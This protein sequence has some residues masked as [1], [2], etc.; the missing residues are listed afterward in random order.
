MWAAL[1]VTLKQ[2]HLQPATSAAGLMQTA[3]PSEETLWSY[4]VQLASALRAVHS[5]HLACHAA[6][7][8]P[9]KVRCRPLLF[10]QLQKR[11]GLKLAAVHGATTGGEGGKGGSGG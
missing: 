2:A 3:A 7:L 6:C 4:L 11:C 1:Q 10:Q 8:S 9:S 5:A